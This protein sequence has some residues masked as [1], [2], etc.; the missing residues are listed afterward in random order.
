M[1]TILA[2]LAGVMRLKAT[3][4]TRMDLS[5][6]TLDIYPLYVFEGGGLTLNAAIDLSSEVELEPRSDSCIRI[7]SR[8]LGLV[9]EAARVEDLRSDGEY[10][11]LDLI[12]RILQFYKVSQGLNLWTKSNVPPGSGLG[13][14]SSLLISLSTALLQLEGLPFSKSQIIDFGAHIEAQSIRIPTGKQD[15]YP[16]AFGGFN[17]LWFGLD[18][19]RREPLQFSSS[20]QRRLQEQ[21][22]LGYTGASRFS[23]TSNWNMMKRYIDNQGTTVADMRRIKE[24]ALAMYQS[25]QEESLEKFSQCLSREWDIRRG[26]AEG[27]TTPLIDKI[28]AA[29]AEHG[30]L[31]GKICGAGGGGCFI[32]LVREGSQEAVRKAIEENGGRV[33]DYR[34]SPVGV[35]VQEFPV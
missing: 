5:G 32:T 29:A 19:D 3:A 26:L 14:S 33:L 12:V 27:V 2:K 10:A 6:A 4:P 11:P 1:G 23:G 13:G 16:P 22:L 8:D 20:F 31:A 7:E 15:Y 17:A 18:G 24:T 30:A 35:Q 9:L 34:F 28:F 21:I 25:L